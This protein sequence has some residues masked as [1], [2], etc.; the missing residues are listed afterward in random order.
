MQHD[1]HVKRFQAYCLALAICGR[2][3]VGYVVCV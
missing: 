3:M 2:P 1:A